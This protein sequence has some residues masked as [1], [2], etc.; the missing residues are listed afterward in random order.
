MF[1]FAS[2]VLGLK[3]HAIATRQDERFLVLKKQYYHHK[4]PFILFLGTD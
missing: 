1:I 3:E 2:Q 4:S